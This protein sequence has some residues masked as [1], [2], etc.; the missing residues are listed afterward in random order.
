MGR[1][2]MTR[3]QKTAEVDTSTQTRQT[4]KE[5]STT[6]T[7]KRTIPNGKGLWSGQ[8]H[9]LVRPDCDIEYLQGR[10]GGYVSAITLADSKDSLLQIVFTELKNRKLAPDDEYD[11]IEELTEK[12]QNGDLSDEWIELCN[13]ALDT[14][15]VAFNAFNLYTAE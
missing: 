1:F 11:E 12:Y 14:G 3:I 7:Q 6:T 2:G 5:A 9:F 15:Q 4:T 13:L 8:F 10:R